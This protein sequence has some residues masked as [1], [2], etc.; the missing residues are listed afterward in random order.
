MLEGVRQRSADTRIAEQVGDRRSEQP[1]RRGAEGRIGQQPDHRRAE[2][3]SE[4]IADHGLDGRVVRQPGEQCGDG[5]SQ[6]LLDACVAEHRGAE[7]V[8]RGGQGL[9]QRR[10]HP[11]SACSASPCGRDG[12]GRVGAGHHRGQKLAAHPGS[13]GLNSVLT[14]QSEISDPASTQAL[15]DGRNRPAGPAA[16]R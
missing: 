2:V 5:G 14:Q 7:R 3:A 15:P 4:Q 9:G 8:Q 1:G 12:V 11:G 16:R 13:G 10:A 6:R